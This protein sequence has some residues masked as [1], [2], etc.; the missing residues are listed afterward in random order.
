MKC[1]FSSSAKLFKRTWEFVASLGRAT[2]VACAPTPKLEISFENCK[3]IYRLEEP[4]ALVES[5]TDQKHHCI[6]NILMWF[7][8]K[9]GQLT[10]KI[11]KTFI[12]ISRK[13]QSSHWIR[14]TCGNLACSEEWVLPTS[15]QWANHSKLQLKT[16]ISTSGHAQTY[17]LT[18]LASRNIP[19]PEM[20]I[21]CCF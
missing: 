21:A 19:W 11:A 6:Q 3:L 5:R 13:L 12:L 20:T 15:M 4:Q 16:C 2:S 8:V 7:S 9:C 18:S 1:F 10:S 14:Q 17:L